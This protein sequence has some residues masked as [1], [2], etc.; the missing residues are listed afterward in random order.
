[1]ERGD[2]GEVGWHPMRIVLIWE[3]VCASPPERPGLRERFAQ[4]RGRSEDWD[5]AVR[6]W[7]VHE[8]PLQRVVAIDMR[9]IPV[10]IVTFLGEEY[11]DA[12]RDRLDRMHV[13]V[14]RVDWYEDVASF[15]RDLRM[16]PDVQHVVDSDSERLKHYGRR[17]LAVQLGDDWGRFV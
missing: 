7:E 11:A 6:A 13:P 3:G 8:K 4:R 16:S 17:G 10:D 9:G 2:I 14:T 15:A 5:A 12:L 1:M